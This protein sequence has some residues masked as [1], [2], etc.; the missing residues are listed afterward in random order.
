MDVTEI[1]WP[2]LLLYGYREVGN[3]TLNE[4][5]PASCS[6]QVEVGLTLF[7]TAPTN[8]Q[9]PSNNKYKMAWFYQDDHMME[10][11]HGLQ[12]GFDVSQ[13]GKI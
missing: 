13:G 10:T 1:I 5:S 8:Q 12:S 4:V 2:L 6:F 3:P 9:F 11:F 7:W